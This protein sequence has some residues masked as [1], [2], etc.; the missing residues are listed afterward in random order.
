ML[1]TRKK[2]I[3]YSVFIILI[4]GVFLIFDY[5]VGLLK[6]VE[7]EFPDP[8]PG[9]HAVQH[10]TE[11]T[12]PIEINSFQLRSP[13]IDPDSQTRKLFFIGDSFVFGAT[14]REDEGFTRRT[15]Y[16]LRAEGLDVDILNLGY[17]LQ[18][19]A[20]Y[21]ARFDRVAEI[22]EPDALVLFIYANDITDLDRR[23]NFE[24]LR[25]RY[26]R[27]KAWLN[28]LHSLLPNTVDA[29][30]SGYMRYSMA[31]GDQEHVENKDPGSKEHFATFESEDSGLPLE[32][33]KQRLILKLRSMAYLYDVPEER[34]RNWLQKHDAIL[35]EVA[36]GK[37][38]ELLVIVGLLRPDNWEIC[39]EIPSSYEYL[40][41]QLEYN[42]LELKRRAMKRN[43]PFAVVYIPSELQFDRRKQDVVR[44]LGYTVKERW[45]T[46]TSQLESN[47]IALSATE[48]IPFLNLTPICRKYSDRKMVWDLDLHFNETGNRLVTPYIAEFV[49]NLVAAD[50][51]E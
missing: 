26:I 40:W 48:E 13:E 44:E 33:R 17:V 47:L 8:R 30:V 2:I 9:L 29:I 31:T 11:Y 32:E 51:P 42:I 46:E 35:N 10:T 14:V 22:I 43:I 4:C 20:R 7:A 5:F 38:P 36:A 24:R 19:P 1:D 15:E 21:P 37:V 45:L 41:D 6:P 50:M 18:S 28:V 39:L 16:A 25:A 27:G 23:S 49:S 12:I 34:V 3:F